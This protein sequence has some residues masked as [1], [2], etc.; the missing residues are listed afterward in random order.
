MRGKDGRWK[1]ERRRQGEIKMVGGCG[2][3]GIEVK[4]SEEEE[5]EEE[6]EK[7]GEGEEEEEEGG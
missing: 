1:E 4:V 7:K 5:E 6:K 3:R 2:S